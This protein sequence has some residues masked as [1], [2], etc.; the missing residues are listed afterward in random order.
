MNFCNTWLTF[1]SID[2]FHD[3]SQVDVLGYKMMNIFSVRIRPSQVEEFN[4]GNICIHCQHCGNPNL[5]LLEI[6]LIMRILFGKRKFHCK[7]VFMG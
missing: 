4:F 1:E 6:N 5:I 7:R 2:R 3:H